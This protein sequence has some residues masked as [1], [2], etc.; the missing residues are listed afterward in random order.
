[1]LFLDHAVPSPNR[2]LSNDHKFLRDFAREAGC[3]IFKG[4][5]GVCHQLVAELFAGSGDII[6]G[7]D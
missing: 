7:A 2:A 3:L 4:G 1:M 6:V 5:N